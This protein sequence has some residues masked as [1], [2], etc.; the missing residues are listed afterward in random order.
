MG[1]VCHNLVA[2]PVGRLADRRPAGIEIYPPKH[3]LRRDELAPHAVLGLDVDGLLKPRQFE[4]LADEEGIDGL[5]S[6]KAKFLP[7]DFQLRALVRQ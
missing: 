4:H 1:H 3:K 7:R 6:E 2:P 5:S